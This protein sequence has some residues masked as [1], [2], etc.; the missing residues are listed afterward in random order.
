MI[1]IWIG[2]EHSDVFF[3]EDVGVLLYSG[4]V[5]NLKVV[6][7]IVLQHVLWPSDAQE[8]ELAH[9][10]GVPHCARINV[11]LFRLLTISPS[12]ANQMDDAKKCHNLKKMWL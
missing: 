3:T 12:F 9:Y 5:G 2:S 1:K 4:V 10:V 8:M 11:L 7:V 6:C